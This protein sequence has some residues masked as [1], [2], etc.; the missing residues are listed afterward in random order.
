MKASRRAVV[1]GAGVVGLTCAYELRRRGLEITILD[2]GDPI[3]ACSLGNAGWIVPTFSTPLPSPGSVGTVLRWMLHRESPFYLKARLDP[4]LLVW[5]YRFWRSANPADYAWGLTALAGL[6]RETMA[7]YDR[8]RA[9]GVAFE[10]QEQGMLLA[11]TT[12]EA[13]RSALQDFRA[14]HALGYQAAQELSREDM[15][16]IEPALGPAVI[17]GVL[18]EGERHLR[19]ESLIAGLRARLGDLGVEIREVEV[20]GFRRTGATIAAASTAEGEVQGDEFVIAAGAWSA[21]VLAALKYR[22]PLEAGKGYSI[23]IDRPEV[24]IRRPLYLD[25]ARVALTP[26][27]RSVRIS[28]T[29]ELSG[30]TLRLDRRRLDALRRAVERYLGAWPSGNGETEWVGVRP[31]TSDGLPVIG[32]VPGYQNA[33]VITGHAMMGM[34]LAPASAAVLADLITEG[35][36]APLAPFDPARF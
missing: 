3:S 24:R 9:D 6:N 34:T 32:R 5:L 15:H 33:F 17:A 7:L 25:E 16:R 14:L 29:M 1:V 26:F 8:L 20:T 4:A 36:S 22:L 13:M 18:V 23:T 35:V 28:G 11:F 2:R 30:L 10:M 12:T 21:R 31:L 19:P 27:D